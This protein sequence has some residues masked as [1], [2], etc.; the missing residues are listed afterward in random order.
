YG[1]PNISEKEFAKQCAAAA[2]EKS[3]AE[4]KKVAA[5]YE[6]K[7]DSIEAKLKREERELEEDEAEYTQRKREEA[8]TAAET[9]FSLFSKRRR[10]ISSSMTKRRMTAKAKADIE[11]SEDQIEDFQED[12][13]ELEQEAE[14]ALTEIKEKWEAIAQETSIIPVTPTKSSINLS[15]FGVAWLPQ[16]MVQ[17]DED[18]L[19]LAGFG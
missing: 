7:I 12:I 17:V 3:D 15:L 18:V 1:G 11:E 2:Q 8:V 4:S 19:L 5:Q 6:K 10:S 9:L 13:E 14:E 16:H